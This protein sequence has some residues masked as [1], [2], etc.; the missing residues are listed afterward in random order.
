M[1]FAQRLLFDEDICALQY[2]SS[3]TVK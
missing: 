2:Q 1:Q 3:K